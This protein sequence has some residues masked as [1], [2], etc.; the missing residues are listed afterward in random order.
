MR[1]PLATSS[2]EKKK[3]CAGRDANERRSV[4]RRTPSPTLP[5]SLYVLEVRALWARSPDQA[6]ASFASPG[7]AAKP[8]LEPRRP[9]PGGGAVTGIGSVAWSG[10]LPFKRSA[11]GEKVSPASPTPDQVERS[12]VRRYARVMLTQARES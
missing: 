12:V 7:C 9:A 11:T 1:K 10:V 3:S 6:A 4:A 8:C 5:L 2:G